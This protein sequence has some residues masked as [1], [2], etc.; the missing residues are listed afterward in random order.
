M[1]RIKDSKLDTEVEARKK[2]SDMRD[3]AKTHIKSL[4]AVFEDRINLLKEQ[5]V[6]SYTS[7]DKF[8]RSVM[9]EFSFIYFY[10]F[11]FLFTLAIIMSRQMR[12]NYLK[13]MAQKQNLKLTDR[14]NLTI[15]NRQ[16]QVQII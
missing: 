9:Y 14:R 1:K 13:A 5:R 8:I 12:S 3:E 6:E 2:V 10:F 7:N 11:Y 15:Q 16:K 4:Q